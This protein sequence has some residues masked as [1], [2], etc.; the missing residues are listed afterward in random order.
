MNVIPISVIIPVYNAELYLVECLDSVFKQTLLPQE[1]IVIDDG[2]K[3]TSLPIL[4][5]YPQPLRIFSRPNKGL[6]AT[7][8]EAIGYAQNE[9]VAFLDNDDCW[10]PNKLARQWVHLQQH[11]ELD[12]CFSLIQQ[13][14]SPEV[15]DKAQFI[16]PDAP[17]KGVC[18]TAMLIRKTTFERL[19]QFDA[20]LD[21]CDFVDWIARVT[22]RDFRYEVLDEVLA[23]RRIR[24][25]SMSQF[26]AYKQT[27]SSILM[28]RLQEKRL[29]N[30]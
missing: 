14:I 10:N 20:N 26:S 12:A 6:A 27:I 5:N 21:S 4:Q 15:V 7:L 30:Q 2:S 16:V 29:K 17:Q 24:P 1:V 11:P 18:K 19:G 8:N 23:Y 28:G 13:F 9:Y 3:D 22:L 25:N